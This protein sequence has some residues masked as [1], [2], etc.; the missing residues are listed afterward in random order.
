M[1][2]NIKNYN[3]NIFLLAS[4]FSAYH[5]VLPTLSPT[6]LF[7]IRGKQKIA[8][9]MRL[10]VLEVYFMHAHTHKNSIFFWNFGIFSATQT[11]FLCFYQ[12]TKP[13]AFTPIPATKLLAENVLGL[14]LVQWIVFI[15]DFL[16]WL[17]VKSFQRIEAM[18]FY[19]R[20][21]KSVGII[22]ICFKMLFLP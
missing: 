18:Q 22:I 2:N 10:N 8:L 19:L 12:L 17:Y 4:I 9:W 21:K 11:L 1:W 20:L 3:F 7:V 13:T 15:A 16:P 14:A 5:N 6:D